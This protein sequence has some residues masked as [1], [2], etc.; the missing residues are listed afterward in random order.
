ML[1]DMIFFLPVEYKS[2]VA[3]RSAEYLEIFSNPGNLCSGLQGFLVSPTE[4]NI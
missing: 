3:F 1:I 2:I 4:I